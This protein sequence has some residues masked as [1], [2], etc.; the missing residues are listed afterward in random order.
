VGPR[1]ANG[2]NQKLPETYRDRMAELEVM[3]ARLREHVEDQNATI[4]S[5]GES[6][7]RFYEL[8]V[9]SPL[10]YLVH[11][12]SG[13]LEDINSAGEKLLGVRYSRTSKACL[14]QFVAEEDLVLWLNHMRE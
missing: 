13:Y 9:N 5:L 11:D 6:R 4:A 7:S 12:A 2:A 3:V 14:V 1:S 8:F 10:A